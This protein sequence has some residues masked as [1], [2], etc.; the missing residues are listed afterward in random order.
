VPFFLELV[1]YHDEIESGGLEFAGVKPA[2][3]NGSLEEFGKPQYGVDVFKVGVPVVMAFVEGMGSGPKAYTKEE[4]LA[5]FRKSSAAARGPFIYL[6]E[7]VSAEMFRDALGF[8]IEAGS[9]FS[10]VLCGRAT[11]S[12]GVEIYVKKGQ[13]ALEEWLSVTGTENVRSLNKILERATPWFASQNSTTAKDR[14][15]KG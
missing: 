11:W 3:V 2:I 7:G 14:S 5:H 1:A 13:S 6:S 8:A 9:R 10:G 15:V 4:A 12:D